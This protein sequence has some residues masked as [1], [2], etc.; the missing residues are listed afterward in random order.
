MKERTMTKD[1]VHKLSAGLL[2]ALAL[3]GLAVGAWFAL[4]SSRQV[5]RGGD[6][7]G[8]TEYEV[9]SEYSRIKI[10][11]LNNVRTLWFVRDSGEEVVESQQD[12]SRPHELLVDYT[13]F[14]FLSYLFRPKQEKVLIVGLGGGS[15][16]H[17]LKHYDPKVKVDVVEIDPVIVSVAE[18]YFGV[19]SGGNVHII[20]KDA[21]EYLPKTDARYDVIY[22]DAFLKPSRDTDEPGVPLRL[23]TLKFYKEVQKK[24]TPDGLMVFNL[25]PH[26]KINED[27]KTIREAFAQTY[28]FHL[29]EL[30][31][32]VV[33]GS[34]SAKR[35]APAALQ[36]AAEEIDRRF[37]TSYSFR[38]MA[39]RVER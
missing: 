32:L 18:K 15:M 28:V 31:G 30:N 19:K 12:L 25:N 26:S 7:L 14:M 8:K 11:R 22:M 9:K 23:K 38:G 33:V 27:V 36:T 5:G 20:T 39:R 6:R 2:G 24:L 3:V 29:P 34:L 1:R 10:T 17:F 13:R 21:F 16:V 4:D 37:R 35:L